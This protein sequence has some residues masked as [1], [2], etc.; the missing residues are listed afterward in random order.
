M[1][2]E[3]M[4]ISLNEAV[5]SVAFPYTLRHIKLRVHLRLYNKLIVIQVDARFLQ[6]QEMYLLR[7]SFCSVSVSL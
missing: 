7:E 4:P 2:A 5:E 3:S 6:K 1:C